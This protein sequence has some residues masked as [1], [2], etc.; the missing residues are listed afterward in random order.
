MNT[1]IQHKIAASVYLSRLKEQN[2]LVAD[3]LNKKQLQEHLQQLIDK[4]KYYAE[5]EELSESQLSEFLKTI[6]AEFDFAWGCGQ[7]SNAISFQQQGELR[8]TF[9]EATIDLALRAAWHLLGNKSLANSL[10][11]LGE[12]VPGLFVLGLGKLG[13]VDLN[14]SSDVDLVAFFDEASLPVPTTLGK[15]HICNKVLQKMSQLLN[16]NSSV[17][18][19]WRVD[20]RLRPDASAMPLAMSAEPA[21]EYYFYKALPWHRL[22]L[23][24]ARVVAGDIVAGQNFIKRLRPFIWRQNLDYTAIDEL[25]HLKKRI[26]LEH[27][28][29]KLQRK[30]REPVRSE[31]SGFNVK[32]GS[33]GIRE[34]EFIINGLQLLWGGKKVNLRITNTCV[35]MDELVVSKLMEADIAE[36]LKQAYRFFRDLENQIQMLNNGHTHDVPVELEM[37]QRLLTLTAYEDWAILEKTIYKY[38]QW[39]NQEFEQ[40]FNADE[41]TD[42]EKIKDKNNNDLLIQCNWPDS[43]TTRAQAIV[44]AW[45]TG[46]QKYGVPVTMAGKMLPLTESLCAQINQLNADASEAIIKL[47]EFF[48]RLPKSTQ[49]F[50]LLQ[51][52]PALLGSIVPPLIY[53]PP[54]ASLLQ[55]SPHIIDCYMSPESDEKFVSDTIFASTDYE[56]RLERIRRFV[57]EYLYQS[58]L[59]FITNEIE[60]TEFQQYLTELAEHSLQCAMRIVQDELGYEQVP[61]AVLGMGKLAMQCMS[62]LSDLD[63]IFVYDQN[64]VSM[65]HALGFVQRLQTAL[66]VP[67]REGIVYELDTRLRPSGKSGA[68]TVSLESFERHHLQRAHSWEHIALVPGRVILGSEHLQQ[69]IMQIKQQVLSKPRGLTQFKKDAQKM[70][71]RIMEHRMKNTDVQYF[72]SKLR[73]GGLMQ[74]EYLAACYA[75]YCAPDIDHISELDFAQYSTQSANKMGLSNLPEILQFWRIMQLWERLLGSS[76]QKIT[77]MPQQYLTIMLQQLRV[78]DVD[79]L[80]NRVK[81]HSILVQQRFD[82]FFIDTPVSNEMLN[83]WQEIAVQWQ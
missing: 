69:S 71:Q 26:N 29:L 25:A 31:A 77:N 23:M 60:V 58:Y 47:D 15:G 21:E 6:K 38:R 43:L 35:A 45:E 76:G 16:Q 18:F 72:E 27:P 64:Q 50:R 17:N 36:H 67:M 57:N 83:D 7:L 22:A 79:E 80:H 14:F 39:V 4:V 46:F 5:T 48:R 3:T 49:Y 33:G 34:I 66:M 28:A 20:W 32:L 82:A 63:L 55:Q 68:P 73:H 51:E 30:S 78:N 70:W 41:S 1:S 10:P 2:G 81:K 19:I 74:T 12:Y 40:F 61:I 24:K 56:V 8:T 65:E 11:Q 9:A 37:Q 44:N 75:I 53:S 54:M 13:G 59:R 62:P 52:S 42:N